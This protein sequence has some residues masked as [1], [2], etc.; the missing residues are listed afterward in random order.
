MW[1]ANQ[2]SYVVFLIFSNQILTLTANQCVKLLNDKCSKG[3]GSYNSTVFPNVLGHLDFPHAEIEFN[4]FLPLITSFCSQSLLPFLCSVYFPK[5]D[6]QTTQVLPPCTT[7]C[8][9]SLAEC[10]FLF[11][12]Y[13]FDWPS[14]LSCDR[15]A[16]GN[17]CPQPDVSTCSTDV[18]KIT[19]KPCIQYIKKAAT[20]TS[21][22][23]FGVPY[24]SVC[25]KGSSTSFN[26]TNAR[27]DSVDSIGSRLGLD[28][29]K[30]DRTINITYT[31]GEGSYS[32]CGSK[33]RVWNGNYLEVK[34]GDGVYKSYD[35]HLFPKVQWHSAKS[36]FDTLVIYDVG[37]LYVHGIFVNI[38][39]G[40]V[41]SG[42]TIKPYL[43]P[44]PPQ[45]EPNPF[46]FIVYK[47]SNAV[48]V[49]DSTKQMLQ[50]TTDL[51]VVITA[52]G[53]TGPVAL[54]WINVVRDPY[55]IQSLMDLHIADLCPYF[56]TEV[57][58]KHNRPFIPKAT[59][60]DVSLSVTFHPS[61]ITFD[62]CCSSYT[63]TA[64]TITL[65][66]AATTYVNTA[67]V[68]TAVVP[69]VSFTKA[70]ILAQSKITDTYT[71]IC[72]DPD[73]SASHAPI[74]HWM[75]TNIPDGNI[76][77]GQTVLP[78]MGPMPPAGKNHTYYFLLY[79][80]ASPI[81]GSILS[82][83]VGQNC[84]SRC[85]FEINR[86]V[87]DNHLTL[88]GARWMD[89]HY[90]PYVRHLYTTQRGLDEHS[91]CHGVNGY[92]AHCNEGVVVVG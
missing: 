13:G 29:T 63:Q 5:C 84:H 15:F 70:G 81:D 79:T 67:D 87:A 33:V 74:V 54:N 57:L 68:R 62:S 16:V 47:Q 64:K 30:L 19:E 8:V 17:H 73:A 22:F 7:E 26:C 31:Y 80:Q 51:G 39:H 1:N 2:F 86:F 75:V 3:Q 41:S 49:S 66:S 53:L 61:D 92:H 4:Q 88:S 24:K 60:L 82:G 21:T 6:Q 48:V 9:K 36:E 28:L 45:T 34:P 32:T 10:S 43:H 27:E 77:N 65:N 69:S 78:Y 18:T 11:S 35:V 76:Q 58:L 25:P 37:N 20:N 12:F 44:I 14:E 91:V 90:D 85:L 42:Q 50:Q 89:A 72:L 56:E 23:W 38:A 40:V 59:E 52:L 83:Y 55:A 46:A 71:L